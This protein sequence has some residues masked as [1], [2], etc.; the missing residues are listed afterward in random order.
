MGISQW[1]KTISG[2]A[3]TVSFVPTTAGPPVHIRN[4]MVW[5]ISLRQISFARLRWD[6]DCFLVDAV[7]KYPVAEVIDVCAVAIGFFH[8]MGFPDLWKSTRCTG[9]YARSALSVGIVTG[10]HVGLGIASCA[11]VNGRDV[12]LMTK[13]AKIFGGSG[14]VRWMIQR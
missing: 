10:V 14:W 8:G 11:P 4:P 7:G 1:Q 3:V 2:E 6:E 13:T 9:I 12:T 5:R